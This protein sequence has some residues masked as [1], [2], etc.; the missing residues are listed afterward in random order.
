MKPADGI[1]EAFSVFF[2]SLSMA[3]LWKVGVVSRVRSAA[4]NRRALDTTPTF[5]TKH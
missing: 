3:I 2:P 4:Q 5:Q 1:L